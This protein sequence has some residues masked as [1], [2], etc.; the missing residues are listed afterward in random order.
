M[1]KPKLL[2]LD[3][4]SFGLAPLMVR[5]VLAHLR[6]LC[7]AGLGILLVEQDA[8]LVPRPRRRV[9]VYGPAGQARH[10]P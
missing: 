4:A 2:L 9:P 6:A 3:E 7:D 8:R 1:A 5:E 10:L